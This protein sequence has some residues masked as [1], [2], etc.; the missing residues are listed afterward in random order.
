MMGDK[1]VLAL[2][3]FAGAAV[4]GVLGDLLLRQFPWGLNVFLWLAALVATV[5]MIVWL[6]PSAGARVNW[7]ML[8]PVILFA[9][10]FV[11]RASVPLKLMDVLAILVALA[12]VSPLVGQARVPLA[13][14]FHYFAAAVAAGAYAAF[15][16]LAL[17][18]GDIDWKE[19]SRENRGRPVLAVGRGVVLAVPPLL[20]FG[21]LLMSA[22]VVFDNLLRSTFHI[23]VPRLFSHAVLI[24]FCGWIVAGT[25]RRVLIGNNLPQEPKELP[26]LF[27]LGITEVGIVLGL[28]DLLFLA[29]VAV[30]VRYLFGGASLVGITP[31]LSYAEYARRGF[32]ELVA[33]AALVLPLLLAA[34]WLLRQDNPRHARIFRAAAGA[35]IILLF[36]I[37]ASALERMR[38]YT[39]QFG[40]TEQ[41]L[42]AT[43]F[44]AWLAVVFVWFA[45][46]VLRGRRERF[47]FGAMLAG[48]ALIGALQFVNPDALIA[49]TNLERANQGRKFD[50]SY[51]STLSAD[52]VPALAAHLQELKPQD[53]RTIATRILKQWPAGKRS[54]WRSWSWGRARAAQAVENHRAALEQMSG[55]AEH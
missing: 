16:T 6:Q 32:F 52:A 44:M 39:D 31:G 1:T 19:V 14:L 28:L 35:Q 13:S 2:R 20:V 27:S 50:A 46:T 54:D 34:H 41:R 11:W 18:F 15:G 42:C 49:R 48:F 5:P 25:L 7:W 21:V 24:F 29:F 4:M 26:R 36:V 45:L 51:V 33:V 30:Q 12:L 55:T 47:A 22:D 9:V 40:L 37:M 17:V 8:A 53:S 10:F 43:A 3:V 23:N 38:L